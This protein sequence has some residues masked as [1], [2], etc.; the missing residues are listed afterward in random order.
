MPR[1]QP[2]LRRKSRREA[3]GEANRWGRVMG[4]VTGGGLLVVFYQ[5]EGGGFAIKFPSNP[6]R[7]RTRQHRR[8][9]RR[10]GRDD[11][12]RSPSASPATVDDQR[13]TVRVLERGPTIQYSRMLGTSR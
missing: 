1:P 2:V 10:A 9:V 6:G 4:G 13:G 12:A 5:T 8:R 7:G 3:T 11:A